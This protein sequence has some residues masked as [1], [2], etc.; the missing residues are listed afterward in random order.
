MVLHLQLYDWAAM[1]VQDFRVG[2]RILLKDPA[3]SLVAVLGLGVGM[4][5]CILLLGF[6]R[7]SLQY[8]LNVPAAGEVYIVKQRRNAEHA[9]PWY[10]QAPLVVLKAA[11]NAPGVS[12]ASG[13]M[14]WLPF[15]VQV[16]GQVRKINSL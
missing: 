15:T 3:Y 2:L 11:R 13:Y 5:V 1:K 9:A 14:N 7:F 10:D 4:A 12:N 16:D 8:D 6:T